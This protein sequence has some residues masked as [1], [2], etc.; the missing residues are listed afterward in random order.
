MFNIGYRAIGDKT[1]MM[2]MM[3]MMMVALMEPVKN[4]VQGGGRGEPSVHLG[5]GETCCSSCLV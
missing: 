1:T 3:M 2:M 4:I 5:G